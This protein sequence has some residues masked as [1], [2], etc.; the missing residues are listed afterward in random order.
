MH[1]SSVLVYVATFSYIY[2]NPTNLLKEK[3]P[4]LFY[5]K[6]IAVLISKVTKRLILAMSN[7]PVSPR[8]SPQ[9]KVQ[10]SET[11][12]SN[13]HST[14]D[15]DD[16]DVI[17]A[18]LGKAMNAWRD[19]E[20]V[21]DNVE[22][23][24]FSIDDTIK[25]SVPGNVKKDGTVTKTQLSNNGIFSG[26]NKSSKLSLV[27]WNIWFDDFEYKLRYDYILQYV[28]FHKPHIVCL[29]EVTLRFINQLKIGYPDILSEY[30]FSDTNLDS[31]T[32]IPYGV[33][34]LCR[35]ELSPSF[36]FEYFPTKMC[37]KLLVTEFTIDEV[38]FRI[39]TVHLESLNNQPTRE[40][41]LKVCSKRFEDNSGK[42]VSVICGD[43]NFCSYRNFDM[44][45]SQLASH[46][47]PRLDNVCL[48]EILPDFLDLWP[49]LNDV[50]VDK[51]LTFDTKLNEMLSGLG[52]PLER[53]RYD[54]VIFRPP[55]ISKSAGCGD[56]VVAFE[57]Q[58]WR[59]VSMEMIGVEAIS[60]SR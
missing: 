16:N 14:L 20:N 13:E 54:R 57:S 8:S 18:N 58:T 42:Y 7:H 56:S 34:T 26:D 28:R 46:S 19:E 43:F 30:C 6:I 21:A 5:F 22:S 25:H 60:A 11:S 4:V 10:I 45:S 39:G 49:A 51:G 35:R 27:S 52:H 40:Q 1:Y 55:I 29:Q 23:V 12:K 15:A 38:P 9:I 31:V 32:V 37:R 36:S 48:A 47:T 33:A 44:P 24:T 41:Q 3:L 2:I 17:V 53:M 50:T 59:P